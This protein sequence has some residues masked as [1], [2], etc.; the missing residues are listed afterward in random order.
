M[1]DKEWFIL[2]YMHRDDG[3]WKTRD[4][5][6]LSNKK[7]LTESKA[8]RSIR[9]N[10]LDEDGHFFPLEAGLQILDGCEHDWHEFVHIEFVRDDESLFNLK[11]LMDISDLIGKLGKSKKK[12][13]SCTQLHNAGVLPSF[14][15]LVSEVLSVLH[16][17]WTALYAYRGK[18]VLVAIHLDDF[19]TIEKTLEMDSESSAFD[20]EIRRSL[21]RGLKRMVEVDIK[22]LFDL[23]KRLMRIQKE[24]K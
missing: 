3:N 13:A 2:Q 9:E 20:S 15:R 7:G 11:P 17:L 4:T 16:E 23:R 22:P 21:K 1:N 14:P 6:L 10:L 18:V 24:T 8:E 12:H 19:H 5:V